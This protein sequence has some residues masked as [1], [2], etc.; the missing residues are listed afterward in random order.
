MLKDE[1]GT[2]N[3]SKINKSLIG[4][5]GKDFIIFIVLFEQKS[6]MSFGVMFFSFNTN[7][8]V[9]IKCTLMQRAVLQITLN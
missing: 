8:I 4:Q 1:Q 2:R 6:I 3:V 5:T 9:D 7:H